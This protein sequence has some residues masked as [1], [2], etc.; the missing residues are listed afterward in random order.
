M[1]FNGI[2]T[3]IIF[4]SGTYGLVNEHIRMYNNPIL[5]HTKSFDRFRLESNIIIESMP[6]YRSLDM[7]R[8]KFNNNDAIFACG[9]G[10][11]ID[12][13][14]LLAYDCNVPLIAVPTIFGSGSEITK[15]AVLWDS[16]RKISFNDY[17]LYPSISIIDPLLHISVPKEQKVYSALDSLC[18][19]YEA[20]F[21]VD[22]N[23]YIYSIV[24]VA[25]GIFTSCLNNLG[26]SSVYACEKYALASLF[27]A[28][29]MSLVSTNVCHSLSYPLT[30]RFG[31]PHGLAAYVHLPWFIN[32]CTNSSIQNV[33]DRLDFLG[34]KHKLSDYG[35]S[36]DDIEGIVDEA[37]SYG[38]M[39]KARCSITKAEVLKHMEEIL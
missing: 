8:D 27:S 31:M 21:H 30:S 23:S 10:S 33:F 18:H 28:A 5:L 35:V 13:G 6:S 2:P 4:G 32:K 1:I 9:G 14:K 11:V 34:I 25:I 20:T 37:F 3:S 12:I 22:L 17:K 29:A 38:K 26:D 7:A 39:N 36:G 15:Y 24:S 19:V 16:G